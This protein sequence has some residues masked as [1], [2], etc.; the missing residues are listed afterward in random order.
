M[1]HTM[2]WTLG[3]VFTGM[4]LT[5]LAQPDAQGAPPAG[6][7]ERPA[8]AQRQGDQPVITL[9]GL[10]KGITSPTPEKGMPML[11]FGLVTADQTLQVTVAPPPFLQRIGLT[12]KDGAQ[13][14][15]T[16][17]KNPQQDQ[18]GFVAR[19]ITLDG[20][21]YPIRDE[22]G[23]LLGGEFADLPQV[24]L[25]GTVKEVILP[26]AEA[27]PAP[28]AAG[29][30]KKER[31]QQKMPVVRF[32]LQTDKE[33]VMVVLGPPR[34]LEQLGLTLKDGAKV[35]VAG[36]KRITPK[37]TMVVAKEITVEGKTTVL[38]DAEGRPAIKPE[39]AERPARE[40]K[41][42]GEQRKKK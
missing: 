27:H 1:R 32:T 25:T 15:V 14:S 3:L 9:A 21:A 13:V 12:L 5:A 2:I 17:W 35:T 16:G 41:Q 4:T 18:A 26:D 42:A 23:R 39:R 30:A 7:R 24:T 10:I 37:Q 38:R 6:K 31:P 8:Q 28:P 20:K 33:A 29:K 40:R 22:K 36:W 11:S 19:E 34:L